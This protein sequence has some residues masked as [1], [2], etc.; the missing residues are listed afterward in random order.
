MTNPVLQVSLSDIA[1]L[2]NVRRPVVSMWRR[3]PLP[4]QAFPHPVGLV[5]GEER[6]DA[7]EVAAYL[8]STGRGNNREVTEDLVAHAKLTQLANLDEFVTVQGLTALLCLASMTAASLG[9]L[10]LAELRRLAVLTRQVG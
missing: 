4:G 6:F 3:R 2:A 8:A 7:H 10:S 1:R 9:D 5:S